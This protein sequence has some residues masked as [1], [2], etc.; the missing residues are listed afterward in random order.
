MSARPV[1]Y[2][3]VL[4]LLALMPVGTVGCRRGAQP[5]GEPRYLLY[6]NQAEPEYLDPGMM[7]GNVELRLSLALFEG[8][9]L[10]D[11]KD[12]HPIPG[13]AE[14]WEVSRDG[15]VYTFFLRKDAKWSDGHSVTAHDFVYAWER[16]LNPKT[17]A[18]YSFALYYIKNAEAYN[19][20]K[21]TDP[22][23][24]GMKAINDHTLQVTLENP[25]PYF[26]NLTSY[27]PYMPLPRW[28]IERHG[29]NWTRPENIVTNGPFRLTHWIPQKEILVVKN[30]DYWDAAAVKLP[31]IRFLPVDD[32]ATALKMYE[33]GQVDIT[34]EPPPA[35]LPALMGR[36]DLV[37][38]AFL[39]TYLYRLNT[40]RPPLNDARVRR[41][42]AMAIDR[43]TLCESY[44]QRAKIPWASMVPAGLSGYTPA[45]GP[46][47]NPEEARRL[48]SEAGFADPSAF[49]PVTIL[50]NTDEGHRLIAQVIQQMWRQHLGIEV[51]LQNQEWKSYLKEMRQLNYDI[52]RY[53]WIADYPDP[54]TFLEIFLSY[55]GENM[56]GWANQAFDRLLSAAKQEP[57]N[58]KRMAI[59]KQAE[60]VLLREVPAIPIYTYVRWTLVKPH[61]KGY[62]PNLLD[63]HPFKAI[64]LE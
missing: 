9:T 45:T 11:P 64:S 36:P 32:D 8:L 34:E 1:R 55:A 44:L 33:G 4:F 61:V 48:L 63:I 6:N 23:I 39:A 59:L 54:T 53:G 10:Y 51:K 47:F 57:N 27:Y 28:A 41:A 46:D 21:L 12:L 38:S 62:Y 24:L 13:T 35:Q 19:T 50:Y 15:R 58:V 16:I 17:G 25:T 22:A 18:K 7:S 43:V 30:P 31:G 3:C 14:R 5:S 60:E 29:N 40:T 26:L 42:L 37:K 52:A 2:L 56:T 49:P 20:G